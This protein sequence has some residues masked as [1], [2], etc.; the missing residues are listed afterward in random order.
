MSERQMRDPRVEPSKG[1]LVA[2]SNGMRYSV[3]ER[4]PRTVSAI[5]DPGSFC[6]KFTVKEW[7]STFATATIIHA[8]G[9]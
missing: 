3:I 2:A 1:D 9:E 8:E 5:T 6:V 7:R 4:T